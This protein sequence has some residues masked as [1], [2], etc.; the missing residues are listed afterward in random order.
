[1]AFWSSE[2]LQEV[3]PQQKLV[4]PFKA[5]RIKHAAYEL[6]LG[7]EVITTDGENRKKQ[8]L[9]DKESVIIQPGHFGLLLTEELV[10]IPNNALG[11]ISM[12]ASYKFEGL[13]N[14][15]GFHVDP[16]FSGRLKFAV[17][18]ASPTPVYISRGNRVF[19][20][21]LS[22]L[23]RETKDLYTKKVPEEL[24]STDEKR[25]SGDIISLAQLK[26]ELKDVKDTLGHI[27][28]TLAI[29]GP[30]AV[31][32]FVRMLFAPTQPTQ[33]P[34][35]IMQTAQPPSVMI[36][37]AIQPLRSANVISTNTPAATT[38]KP[39]PVTPRQ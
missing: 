26:K 24:T 37:P 28:L 4:E 30:I 11:F 35:P 13:I 8:K 18:N 6:S 16:G 29:L 17:F 38:N 39:H 33:A 9:E 7:P 34:Q 10:N 14:V 5:D 1:M 27:K 3:I 36:Q 12:R 32:F 31:G 25:M 23:D 19:M 21:W 20:L 15:S 22:D 2:K